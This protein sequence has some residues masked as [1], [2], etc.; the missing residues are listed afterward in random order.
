MDVFNILYV[1]YY[2]N[3]KSGAPFIFLVGA[4]SLLLLLVWSLSH[5]RH[6]HE[7]IQS[8]QTFWEN[9]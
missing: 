1:R 4:Y 6:M 3:S 9:K 5:L 7:S 2:V 8:L